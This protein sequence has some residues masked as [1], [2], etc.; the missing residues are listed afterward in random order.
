MNMVGR[1]RKRLLILFLITSII[2]VSFTQLKTSA[3]N[4]AVIDQPFLLIR[5]EEDLSDLRTRTII[6]HDGNLH[7][8]VQHS[9]WNGTFL[10][11]HILD[12]QIVEVERD[13]HRGEIFQV[14]LSDTGIRLVYSLSGSFYGTIVRMYIWTEESIDNFIIYST[15]EG[16][17]PIYF[18]NEE[19]SLNL[20]T[21][22]YY[23]EW[24]T[25]IIHVRAF[26][27][28]T[29]TEEE[30]LTPHVSHQV[31]GIT[32]LNQTVYALFEIEVEE[33]EDNYYQELELI[34][35]RENGYF[36]STNI[37]LSDYRWYQIGLSVGENF[38]F[39]LVL[40]TAMNG[41][42]LSRSFQVNESLEL[43]SFNSLSTGSSYAENIHWFSYTNYSFYAIFKY[44]EILEI[45]DSDYYYRSV[46]KL[47]IVK[48][49]YSSLSSQTIELED[50]ERV[51]YDLSVSA[52]LLENESYIISYSSLVN[53]A[54][55]SDYRFL[56]R[57]VISLNIL[58]DIDLN[59]PTFPLLLNLK[60]LSVF[61][62]FWIR[63]WP[64]IIVPILA[65]GLLYWVFHKRINHSLR[66]LRDYLLRPI[67][68][69]VSDIDLVFTN[70]WLF[71]TN[72][73]SLIFSLWK[74]NKKRLVIS[75]L[76]LTILASIIVTSTTL[77]DSKRDTLIVNHVESSDLGNDGTVTFMFDFN[78]NSDLSGGAINENVTQT[79]LS[80]IFS[81]VSS[82]TTVLSNSM[83]G[84]HYSLYSRVTGYNFS[85]F[86]TYISYLGYL[87]YT[88]NYSLVLGSIL[89]EGRVPENLNEVVISTD[90]AATYDMQLFDTIIINATGS[91]EMQVADSVNFTIVGI[92]LPPTLSVLRNIC[93]AN[94]VPFDP[95]QSLT[96]F[97]NIVC[98][99]EYY[100]KNFENATDYDFNLYGRIQLLYNF[101]EITIDDVNTLLLEVEDL[102]QNGPYQ[103]SFD[104]NGNWRVMNEIYYVF[105][106]IIETLQIT[107]FLVIFLSIPILYLAWFLIF[108][109]NELFGA[110]FAQEI[111][112][113]RSKGV[114]TGNI[115][116][117]Y[118]SMKFIESIIATALGFVVTLILIPPLL[119]V[120]KFVSFSAQSI[121]MSFDSLAI[122]MGI[123]FVLLMFVSLPRIIKQSRTRKQVE[124]VPRR[125]VQL[126]KRF[127][128]HYFFIIILG[129]SITGLAFWMFRLFGVEVFA[130]GSSTL[131]LVFV[132]LI[133]IGI[134][135]TLLGLGL[136]LKELHKLIMI[137]LSKI[138]WMSR[139]SLFS[140]SLV[141][142][143]SDINLFNNT[144]LTYL[145]LIGVVVPF[146]VTPINIQNKME[147]ETY[148]YKGSDLYIG[149][150]NRMNQTLR[151]DISLYDEVE[152]L[153]NVTV[154]HGLYG[155]E[156]HLFNV[157]VL[158]DIESFL[159][160]VRKPPKYLIND[161]ESKI[162][163]LS[164]NNTI[165]VS[166]AFDILISQERHTYTFLS[167]INGTIH[168]YLFSIKAV[169]DYF[170]LFYDAGSLARMQQSY[171]DF[172]LVTTKE[173]FLTLNKTLNLI[174]TSS[175]LLLI[176]TAPLVN[177]SKLSLKLENELNLDVGVAEEDYE[178]RLTN[179]IP[180]YSLVV[181]EFIFG[182]LVCIAAVIF[183][184]ISNPMKILQRRTTK[185]DVLK[186]IGIPT[187]RIIF[188]SALELFISC[189]IP[190]LAVG[191]VAGYGLIK[192]LNYI[193][194]GF[195]PS[196]LP[197]AMPFPYVVV[198]VVF[199]GIPVVF[200][201]IF[202]LAMKRN[203]AK[204][205]PRNLE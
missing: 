68:T 92:Y 79:A 88:N 188:L 91:P 59:L 93:R 20:F 22:L 72:A 80:E 13:V 70:I 97:D 131:V 9:Y 38:R 32:I 152:N 192:L 145:I 143:R 33:T 84:F 17:I 78:L 187:N 117:I 205:M 56:N 180:F 174:S 150:W 159:S 136:I 96:S 23:N 65:L 67:K 83:G 170:P 128:L 95:I 149:N 25:T 158:D 186:K 86:D 121:T 30:Y 122:V 24:N 41:E 47:I 124:K 75:L 163:S 18:Q 147:T 181:A 19:D 161:W 127:R 31:R 4:D 153:T 8:F 203:F 5:Y 66:K 198:L 14:Y 52:L 27:N 7:Y 126:L 167:D 129:A 179:L 63:Y 113:L 164:E 29:I 110:S 144:F 168:E 182:I 173:N 36:N 64:A 90:V 199:L 162:Q 11:Y 201:A 155:A 58:S 120:D 200:Y 108:E 111:R 89:S 98:P 87:G 102:Q 177:P 15:Y 123:S 194:L 104:A 61:T 183:T 35:V 140:F 154:Y 26:D 37:R 132:Y 43:S 49:D 196:A 195:R 146:I 112:I 74:A 101:G 100:L 69:D 85:E 169:F 77:F 185:H 53:T 48:D 166:N 40:Y 176:K 160:T 82:S 197:Y 202:F 54:D 51:N 189:I 16:Y 156:E 178:A 172:S 1:L 81:K 21:A 109:V 133:G 190:G 39:R 55:N 134:M 106:D 2:F 148:F 103:F 142:I 107:Q 105:Y 118:S 12:N 50:A 191:A 60:N 125:M 71:I 3:L 175:D 10:I 157:L 130:S 62:Y 73:V 171:Y 184:S 57:Q 46:P 137:V 76:G 6:D 116:F 99:I 28:Q 34:G 139:K 114:S 44:E 135:I 193:L 141:E 42:L 115:S 138:S 165:M 45:L 94:D 204:Y 119:K 151:Y